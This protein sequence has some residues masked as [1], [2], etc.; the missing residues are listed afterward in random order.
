MSFALLV[1]NLLRRVSLLS[2]VH[3]SAP[4][5]LD[6]RGLIAEAA[7]VATVKSDLQ[8]CDWDR[9]SNRQQTKMTLGGFVGEV[10]YCGEKASEYLP[11]LAAG[12]LLHVGTGSAFGLGECCMLS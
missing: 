8:W 3:G 6:Y 2:A 12:E 5:E 11:L 7:S 1:R 4:L 10:V 9:Y